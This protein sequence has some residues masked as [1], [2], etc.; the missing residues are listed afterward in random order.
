M[1][2]NEIKNLEDKDLQLRYFL[3][4]LQ[5]MTD[6]EYCH[7][8]L[9]GINCSCNIV[10]DDERLNAVKRFINKHNITNERFI[11]LAYNF[12]IGAITKYHGSYS[13]FFL[14]LEEVIKPY[15]FTQSNK[16]EI[17][18]NDFREKELEKLVNNTYEP[19]LIIGRFIK[20]YNLTA[21]DFIVISK[22]ILNHNIHGLQLSNS[23][24]TFITEVKDIINHYG[25]NDPKECVE[26]NRKENQDQQSTARLITE[27][28]S[29]QR[30]YLE[31]MKEL[32]MKDPVSATGLI[33]EELKKLGFSDK[34][35]IKRLIK[36]NGQKYHL[37]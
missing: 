8:W 17:P 20:K 14:E 28:K 22:T 21:A 19:D 18:E 1:K 5:T 36:G 15:Q 4:G 33:T 7:Y 34:K 12:L 2:K 23:N 29:A 3:G 32:L 24:D 25:L 11:K 10:P 16:N 26:Q 35:N 37:Y 31:L 30:K 27:T 13:K 6:N 9:C